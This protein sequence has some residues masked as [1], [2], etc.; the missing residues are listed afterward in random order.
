[1]IDRQFH[2]E[3]S[4]IALGE[5]SGGEVA[6]HRSGHDQQRSVVDRFPSF[7]RPGGGAEVGAQAG[8]VV[9]IQQRLRSGLRRHPNPGQSGEFCH[10]RLQ[11]PAMDA[12]PGQHSDPGLAGE[13]KFEGLAELRDR[14]R[15]TDHAPQRYPQ[16]F[17]EDRR[18]GHVQRHA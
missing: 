5:E 17:G 14:G 15:L 4:V 2:G 16:R 13:S 7:V 8:G 11:T 18:V 3:G 12:R 10:S 9:L 1:M 6:F